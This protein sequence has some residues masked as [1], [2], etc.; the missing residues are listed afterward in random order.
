MTLQDLHRMQLMFKVLYH[1]P[2]MAEHLPP[3]EQQ[4]FRDLL[5][6]LRNNKD[7]TDPT[8]IYKKKLDQILHTAKEFG[9][10]TK[11]EVYFLRVEKPVTPTFYLLPKLES[12]A[13][14]SMHLIEKLENNIF[15]KDTIVGSLDVELL[16]TNINHKW[17]S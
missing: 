13:R 3:V 14:D 8:D 9:V 5:E 6:L 11:K 16:Y 4:S 2:T 15:P 10:L 7:P 1:R 17:I 12:Y